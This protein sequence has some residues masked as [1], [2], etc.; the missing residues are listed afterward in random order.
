M[1]DVPWPLIRSEALTNRV[2][3]GYA[4]RQF[5]AL[6]PGIYAPTDAQITPRKRA[7][8]AWLWSRR[9]GTIAGI[10]AAAL[11][12]TKWLPQQGPAVLIHTNRRA[13]R[14]ITLW[15]D[16]LPEGERMFVDGLPVTTPARTAFDIGRRTP[17]DLAV[18]HLDALMNATRLSRTDIE[19]VATHHRG[20][21]GLHHLANV[22]GLVDG[23]AESPWET[24]TR[25][26]VVRAG[27]PAPQTQ[28][29]VRNRF[30][31]FVARLD[32]G[33]PDH[34]VGIEFDGAQHWTSA[35]QRTRDIDRATELVDEGWRI[36]RVSSDMV[37]HRSGTI[38]ARV[39][40][41]FVAARA[42]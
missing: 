1:G 13:P 14:G 34:R 29:V 19:T 12:G 39:A 38:L 24:R 41:A 26:L 8:A 35:Q 17:V 3:T 22:L 7:E 18:Q 16:S 32:M 15:S 42:A 6:Y 11:H 27:F 9:K 37:R 10:S 40:E 23:G 30:G 28:L 21:R 5:T 2:V 36:I 20:A 4:L 25:L 33:W 31:D